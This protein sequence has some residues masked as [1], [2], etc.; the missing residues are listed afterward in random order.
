MIGYR[1]LAIL[2]I[3]G[4]F[5][6]CQMILRKFPLNKAT[7]EAEEDK[8]RVLSLWSLAF[9]I[10]S[11]QLI[12]IWKIFSVAFGSLDSIKYIVFAIPFLALVIFMIFFIKSRK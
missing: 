10:I 2:I 9:V 7:F 4:G 12:Y 5:W 1:V 8:S 11:G 3:G 6:I